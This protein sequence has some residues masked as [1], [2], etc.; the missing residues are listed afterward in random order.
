MP[1]VNEATEER[2]DWSWKHDGALDGMYVE[3]RM[4]RVKN[5]PSAG[6]AKAVLDFHVGPDDE[7]VTAWPT[8]VVRNHLRRE[9]KPPEVDEMAGRD[10][11]DDEV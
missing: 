10:E 4:V 8:T 7:L 5:G 9:L 11:S 3:T 1:K 6:K 2:R